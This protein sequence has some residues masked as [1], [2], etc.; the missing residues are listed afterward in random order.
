M[1][2]REES[3]SFQVRRALA[4]DPISDREQPVDDNCVWCGRQ[5]SAGEPSNRFY[6]NGTFMDWHS[7]SITNE[8]QSETLCQDCRPL[9]S[10]IG[11]QKTTKAV[12]SP[13]G[14]YPVK[15]LNAQAHFLME[16]PEPPFLFA[17]A[18]TTNQ[19]HIWWRTPVNHSRSVFAVQHGPRL[20]WCRRDRVLPLRDAV[21]EFRRRNKTAMPFYGGLSPMVPKAGVLNNKPNMDWPDGLRP[22]LENLSPDDLWYLHRV[23]VAKAPALPEPLDPQSL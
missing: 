23:C 17:L 21:L 16:P 12:I 20:I 7:L 9:W 11:Q 5:V 2:P 22:A 1:Y 4:L 6:D 13:A 10:R 15:T 19:M 14:V 3:P 8:R 18:T